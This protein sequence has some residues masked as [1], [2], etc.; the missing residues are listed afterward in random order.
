MVRVEGVLSVHDLHVW[1][2]SAETTALPAHVVLRCID[3]WEPVLLRLRELLAERFG[4]AHVTLQ[5]EPV[6]TIFRIERRDEGR[7]LRA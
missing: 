3:G 2:L 6:E 5:P 7:G 1:S 4:I